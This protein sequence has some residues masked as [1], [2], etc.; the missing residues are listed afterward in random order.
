MPMSAA[1]SAVP[2]CPAFEMKD[3]SGRPSVGDPPPSYAA[4]TEE[5]PIAV[6]VPVYDDSADNLASAP[7]VTVHDFDSWMNSYDPY[8]VEKH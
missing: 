7:T 3:R 6:A 8:N 1:A 4:S 2:P 5:V